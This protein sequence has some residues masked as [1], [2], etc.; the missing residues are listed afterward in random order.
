MRTS[1]NGAPRHFSCLI[2]HPGLGA[3]GS[4]ARAMVLLEAFQDRCATT[5]VTGAPFEVNRLNR[6]YH[7]E[8]GAAKIAIMTAPTPAILANAK[9][10]AAMRGAFFSRFVRQVAKDADLCISAYNFADFGRPGIQFVADFS[11]DDDVRR[12]FDPDSPGLRG[13]LQRPGVARSA[14]MGLCSAVAGRPMGPV[15]RDGDVIV[16]NSRWTADLLLERH[17]LASRVIY[18]PVHTAPIQDVVRSQDFVMLG[19]IAPDKRIVDAIEILDRVRQRGHVFDFHIV[20]E[21]M[22]D[23]YSREVTRKAREAGAWVRLTGGLYGDEKFE[24]LNRQSFA[25][26]MRQREA[27]GIAVAE[28]VKMGLVPFVPEKSAPAEIVGDESVCFKDSEHAVEVID[29]MLRRPREIA[30]VRAGLAKRGEVFSKEAF[31][32]QALELVDEQIGRQPKKDVFS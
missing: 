32:M 1:A 16:A 8:V 19:R 2:S 26:H 11:W 23:A 24:F 4:E 13:A 9:G 12:A 17:G 18:P 15:H 14:Y 31:V 7:T 27:F 25:I 28:M 10:G 30:A 29:K 3:G 20:G 21:M 6:A 5:L 22:D